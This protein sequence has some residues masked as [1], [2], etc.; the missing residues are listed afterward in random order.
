MK[1]YEDVKKKIKTYVKNFRRNDVGNLEVSDLYDLFPDRKA[2]TPEKVTAK[3]PDDYPYQSHRGV[4]II[5]DDSLH[6]LYIGKA[7]M[8]N[9]LGNRLANY[10][11]YADD[12]QACRI[13]HDDWTKEPRYIMTV[14]VP[15]DMPFE[16][17]AL[18]EY[19]VT[20]LQPCNNTQGIN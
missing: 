12:R 20:S 15:I 6:L 8:G 16:A 4:Y 1:T 3:W 11:G 14:A 9:C 5:F 7:S 10:F 19:L 13:W 18:E 17:P 2:K